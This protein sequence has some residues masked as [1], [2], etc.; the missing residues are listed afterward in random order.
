M[1]GNTYQ[2]GYDKEGFSAYQ[3]FVLDKQGY[4][5]YNYL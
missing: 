5:G 2:H 3:E 1:S 4:K